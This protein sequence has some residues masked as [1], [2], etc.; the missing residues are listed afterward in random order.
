MADAWGRSWGVAWGNSWKSGIT[1]PVV[2]TK[3][4][5]GYFEGSGKRRTKADLKAERIRLGITTEPVAVEALREVA[6]SVIEAERKEL[7]L[8]EQEQA[9]L[10]KR[11]LHERGVTLEAH[12]KLKAILAVV[13][14][15]EVKRQRDQEDWAVIQLLEQ[16]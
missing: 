10:L 13:I 2:T 11:V 4:S 1:P 9:E 7:A 16:M 12:R 6:A 3:P 5:G 15:E 14:A 8:K